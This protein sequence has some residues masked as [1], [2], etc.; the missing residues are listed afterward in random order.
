MLFETKKG[1]MFKIFET[2]QI[3]PLFM[4]KVYVDITETWGGYQV[5]K[6]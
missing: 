6:K 3:I 2:W 5:L 4:I 1:K